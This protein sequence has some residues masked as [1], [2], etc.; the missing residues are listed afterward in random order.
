MQRKTNESNDNRLGNC[1]VNQ[2][3]NFVTGVVAVAVALVAGYF[4]YMHW[5]K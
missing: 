3:F 1:N 5:W 2:K 4:A